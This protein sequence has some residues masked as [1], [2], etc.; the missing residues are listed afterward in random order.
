MYSKIDAGLFSVAYAL[1]DALRL[2]LPQKLS[3]TALS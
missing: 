2:E 3:I 1:V